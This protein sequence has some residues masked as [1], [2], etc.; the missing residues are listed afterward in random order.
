[1]H[2][3]YPSIM[4]LACPT[5][6][7]PTTI[8]GH[9]RGVYIRAVTRRESERNRERL[10]GTSTA[11][12]DSFVLCTRTSSDATNGCMHRS[13]RASLCEK[14]DYTSVVSLASCPVQTAT[15]G[16]IHESVKSS[17]RKETSCSGLA[18]LIYMYMSVCRHERKQQCIRA[19]ERKRQRTLHVLPRKPMDTTQRD[20]IC[21]IR[22]IFGP[23]PAFIVK[24]LFFF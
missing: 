6:G 1:M 5:E 17:T 9:K 12:C 3:A 20:I 7:L 8:G 18:C 23:R 11:I 22:A 2:C 16:S 10:D 13:G 24:T 4:F 14:R 19:S 15:K 21:N